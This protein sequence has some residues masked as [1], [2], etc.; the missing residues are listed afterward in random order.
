MPE[1]KTKNVTAPAIQTKDLPDD[2][3]KAAE[4]KD[5]DVWFYATVEAP[6]R[7]KDIVRVAGIN[8]KEYAQNGPL[9]FISG[10]RRSPGPDGRLPVCGK[11][12]EWIKTKHKSL[13]V[14]ALA[15]GIKFA[16]N[17]LGQ[18][19]KELYEGDFLT[20][21][22]IGFEPVKSAPIGGG[23]FDYQESA[24]GELSACITGMNQFS[25]VLRALAE[26]VPLIPFPQD[27]WKAAEFTAVTTLLTD[28]TNQL[29]SLLSRLDDIECAIEAVKAEAPA[30]QPSP[31]NS[32]PAQTAFDPDA[33][34]ALNDAL[35]RFR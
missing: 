5:I 17:S 4:G 1:L 13:G 31:Q 20:D 11:A 6:D 25:G 14:P 8:L 15:V 2:V 16:P 28:V 26:E 32:R 35:K 21:V 24:I 18:E 29:K 9:K 7:E 30:G 19:M 22:S 12:V 34:R 3:V 33:L 23:G 10:H 27:I